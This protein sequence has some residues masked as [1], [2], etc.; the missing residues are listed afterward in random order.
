MVTC[1]KSFYRKVR[2]RLGMKGCEMSICAS[3]F[4][5]RRNIKERTI[6][7]FDSN[8]YHFEKEAY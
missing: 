6:G 1:L 3:L 2:Y 5:L 4:V 7:K 8:L